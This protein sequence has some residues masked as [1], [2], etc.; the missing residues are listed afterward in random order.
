MTTPATLSGVPMPNRIRALPRNKAGYP[1][2]YFAATIDGEPDFRV[3]DP[4]AYAACI[5]ERHCW[6]CGQR[7]A[8]SENAFVIGSMCAVNR[9]SQDPPCH[10]QCAEYAA[11]V[12][13]FMARPSMVRRERGLPENI[14]NAG[15]SIPRNPGACLV[16]ITRTW[17]TFRPGV[18]DG[19]G[20]LF[21]LGD[22][23]ARGELETARWLP[24]AP[25]AAL[26]RGRRV[27]RPDR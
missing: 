14:G 21:R 1:I 18:G 20:V 23:E 27:R 8:R 25:G 19:Y 5:R 11:Q 15:I 24:R 7:R 6:V 4:A 10:V 3:G 26:P 16:W 12:C 17:A 22:P 9:I 2:P 13:P